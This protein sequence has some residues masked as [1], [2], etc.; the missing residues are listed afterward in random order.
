M[1]ISA[2]IITLNEEKNI[3]RCLK[4]IDWVDEIVVVDSGSID[5]TIQIARL[6]GAKVYER[7][8]TNYGDQK[9]FASE[10]AQFDWIF[11]IDAD[12][13]CPE[14]LKREILSLRSSMTDNVNGYLIPRRNFLLGAE[15]KYTRWSPDKH[16]WLYKKDKGKWIGEIHEEVVVEGEVG[17]L[18]S[19]KIH[20]SYENVY[21]FLKM[22][23][24]YT[25]RIAD[26]KV[27]QGD[28]FSFVK[29][30][31]FGVRS[32]FGRYIYKQGFRDGWRGF[33]LSY[34][35][36]IHRITEWIKVWERGE[37]ARLLNG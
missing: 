23:N 12:E 18:K 11:S 5:K 37:Q 1:T 8:F 3:E 6:Y 15:V 4:S 26:Q 16:V 9:N 34:L 13:E 7:D 14:N 17:E 24:S 30:I 31:W 27:K 19:A 32:F 22:M 10:K 21:E 36:M 2:T 28:K 29:M 20:H 35:M 25:N 33:I